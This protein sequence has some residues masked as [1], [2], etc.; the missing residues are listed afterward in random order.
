M[1]STDAATDAITHFIGLF[2]LADLQARL[3]IDYDELGAAAASFTTDPIATLDLAIPH[4]WQLRD[5]APLVRYTP[6]AS[7][8]DVVENGALL[9]YVPVPL[10]PP[11]MPAS[12]TSA[13]VEPVQ[14]D[15]TLSLSSSFSSWWTSSSVSSPLPPPLLPALNLYLSPPPSAVVIIVQHNRLDDNDMLDAGKMD[16]TVTQ[17]AL[18]AGLDGLVQ[19]AD[20]AGLSPELILPATEGDFVVMAA[21]LG[22][23]AASAPPGGATVASSEA[24]CGSFLDGVAGGKR[25]DF[26]DLMPAHRKDVQAREEAEGPTHE[27]VHGANLL[28]NEVTLNASWISAPVMVVGGAS[29]SF[30]L[31]AQVNVW[32]DIDSVAGVAESAWEGLSCVTDACNFAAI[33]HAA[34][35]IPDAVRGDG[36]APAFWAVTTIEGSLVNFNWIEQRNFVSDNDV[37]S[38]TLTGASTTM[39]FGANQSVSAV[40]LFELGSR[41][42]LII[43]DGNLVNIAGIFQT[44]VLLD[45]DHVTL[46]DGGRLNSG[47]NLLVNDASI[48]Q[49]GQTSHLPVSGNWLKLLTEGPDALSDLLDDPAFAGFGA[50]RVLYVKGDLV[51]AQI[52]EQINILGDADQVD[53][54]A[55]RAMENAGDV[56]VVTGSNVL[57]NSAHIA[58]FGIDSAVHTR[59]HVY[60]DALIHQAELVDTGTPYASPGLA[61]EAVVFLADGMTGMAGDADDIAAHVS[62]LDSIPVDPMQTVLA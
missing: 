45:S 52:V 47:D 21:Q 13:A 33:T 27:I 36:G 24:A 46:L 6:P 10:H 28:V 2:E 37:T 31:I 19:M 38:I 40:S 18:L 29:H 44:N 59:G 1:F 57:I 41:F 11:G 61:S 4:P 60:S 50:L 34:F 53:L 20:D 42:D 16:D 55:E 3:R 32:K 35:P 8:S 7:P 62:T 58:E 15:S 54:L 22:Q 51:S 14:S 30:D 43:V 49:V 56:S 48:L 26:D 17:D 9:E 12:D 25:P 39:I 23:A 5:F